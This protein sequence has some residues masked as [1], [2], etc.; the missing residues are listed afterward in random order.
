MVVADQPMDVL[1]SIMKSMQ[2]T[3]SLRMWDELLSNLTKFGLD[4]ELSKATLRIPLANLQFKD[5]KLQ[6]KL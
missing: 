5:R 1:S 6:K 4:N 3:S 2:Q